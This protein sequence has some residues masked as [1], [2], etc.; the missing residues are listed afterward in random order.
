MTAR[1]AVPAYF[2]SLSVWVGGMA[3]LALLVA[4]LAFQKLPSRALAGAY[5][6]SVLQAFSWVEGVCAAVCLTAAVAVQ[7]GHR[8]IS[9]WARA[10]FIALGAMVAI[11]AAHDLYVAPQARSIRA[12]AEGALESAPPATQARFASLHTA[13]ELLF[14]LNL[15][16]GVVLASISFRALSPS[17]PRPE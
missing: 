15:L 14:G 3:V 4:P 2:V 5:F 12:Q 16:L 1:I 11:A 10:Q 7:A 17:A 8:P 13:S 9:G 6:G